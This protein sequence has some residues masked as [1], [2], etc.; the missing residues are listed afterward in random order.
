MTR[1]PA[2]RPALRKAGDAALHPAAPRVVRTPSGDGAGGPA[3][4]RAPRDAGGDRPR[5]RRAPV[6]LPVR[7]AEDGPVSAAERAHLEPVG[8][9]RPAPLVKADSPTPGA[10]GGS[11][12]AGAKAR[13][14]TGGKAGGKTDGKTG[15]ETDGKAGGKSGGKAGGKSAAKAGKAGGRAGR[16][17]GPDS[18]EPPAL[19]APTLTTG[20][21]V[22]LVVT[23]PKELRTALRKRADDDGCTPEEATVRL[24]R[25][26][27][28]D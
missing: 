25:G 11:V 9:L 12:P 27:L 6:I 2:P 3:P 22:K 19:P 18:P 10:A 23:M 20:K 5:E 1:N 24:L 21:A 13:G 4:A 28:S 8:D 15:G 17:S 26:W 16:A 7:P 14:K